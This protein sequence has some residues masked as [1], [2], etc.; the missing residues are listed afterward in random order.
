[1]LMRSVLSLC[2]LSFFSSFLPAFSASGAEGVIR[3]SGSIVE[4]GCDFA[5]SQRQVRVVCPVDSKRVVQTIEVADINSTKIKSDVPATVQ[6][7]Y[8]DNSK[9]LAVLNVVYR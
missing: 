9:K 6:L 4:E 2:C 5:H 3:F 8:L 1:M 7:H